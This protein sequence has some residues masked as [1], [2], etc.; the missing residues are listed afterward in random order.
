MRDGYVCE[1]ETKPGW[2]L[3]KKRAN[4]S[5]RW[6]VDTQTSHGWGGIFPTKVG[7][8]HHPPT[9]QPGNASVVQGEV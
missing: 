1:Q 8:L 6:T 9:T 2:P 5:Q 4:S 7:P 3:A